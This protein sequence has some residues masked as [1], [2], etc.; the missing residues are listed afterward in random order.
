MQAKTNLQKEDVFQDLPIPV[1]LRRMIIP[2]VTS[3]LIVLIYN[4]ADTFFV[5]QTNNP[6]MVAG[7]SLILPVFNITLCLAGLA[8]IGGGSLI[9][10]LLGQSQEEEARRVSAF[11]LYL[12]LF[13]AALFAVGIAIFMEPV[14]GVLG[15]GENTYEYARQYATCVIV[16]GG[17]P[18]VLSNVLANLIR[19]IGRSKEASAGIIL[20]GLLNIALDPLFM[21]VILP[22]GYEVLGAGIATCISNCTAFLFF[23]IV[24]LRMGKDS[25]VT[26]SPRKGLPCKSSVIAVF[27]VGIPSAVT[28]L[29][30]DLDYVII[31]KLM[32]SYHDLALAA[33]GIVLKVERFPLNVGIGI[34][35]GMM[36]LVA[37]N[38][39]AGNEKRMNDTIRLSR[40]LGLIIAAISIVLYEI[41]AVQFAHLF[42]A[43]TQTVELASQFLRIR[44][45]ATPLMFLSF[46]TVYLF[47]AFGKGRISLFLGVTRWLVFNIPMLFLLNA[48]FGMFGIVWSQ[49]TADVLTVALSFYVY[50]KYKP[51]VGKLQK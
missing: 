48:I 18:T 7:T 29:L 38:Y 15:A 13:I 28:T 33:V 20:G 11:S 45:L 47:Q 27:G 25:V 8:G 39:S 41:F 26:F 3:Q 40:S 19:S 46:F 36:P 51:S 16:V 12:G 4:M 14:L 50:Y 17:I 34:C 49:A 31:D 42:I 21:F 37:Y 44:V 6:Y 35:Q 10:R 24:M 2:A 9:S 5:G 22:D 32:V 23:V 1:A 30:F 43:D